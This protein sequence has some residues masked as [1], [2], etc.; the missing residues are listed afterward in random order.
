MHG[1]L[2]RHGKHYANGW[3]Q[4]RL[5]QVNGYPGAVESDHPN[6]KVYGEL[7]SLVRSELLL[8]QLDEY[9]GCSRY[10]PEPH[11]YIRKKLPVALGGGEKTAAWVY[12]FNYD[13]S[14]LI[15]IPS[16]DYLAYLETVSALTG[17]RDS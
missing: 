4:G 2:A 11:E 12:V 15:R 17:R 5:Y 14:K 1:L 7:Y 10:A 6:D 9:E 8:A 16:G 13:V 3:M